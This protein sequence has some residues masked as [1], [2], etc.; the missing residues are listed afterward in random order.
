MNKT[1]YSIPGVEGNFSPRPSIEEARN[2]A[3]EI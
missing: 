1:E 2:V 3:C